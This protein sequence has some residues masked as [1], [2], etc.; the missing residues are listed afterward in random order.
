VTGSVKSA[1]RTI[2]IL[3]QIARQGPATARE[4]SRATRIPESSLSYLLATLVERDWLCSLSDRTYTLGSGLSRLAAGAAP[5]PAE[6][7]RAQLKLVARATGE[8][9]SL[10]IRREHEIEAIEVELSSQLLRF[11]PDRGMRVPLHCFAGGKALLANMSEATLAA[12]LAA[13]PRMRFSPFTLVGEAELR[14]DIAET[15]K[16]GYAISHEEHT[17]GIVGLGVAA[18][19]QFSI[20]VAVP[21]ARFDRAFEKLAARTL[22]EAVK[23]LAG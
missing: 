9:C 17:V 4:I 3:E 10:F 12:Y 14:R 6:R 18:D 22:L 5:S 1:S 23:G 20:S 13:G 11:T 16:R 8:T 2:D 7:R 21:T 19:D 15:R